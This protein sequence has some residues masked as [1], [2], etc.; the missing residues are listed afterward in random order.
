MADNYVR[1]SQNTPLQ[2]PTVSGYILKRSVMAAIS[3]GISIDKDQLVK[4]SGFKCWDDV[5][6]DSRINADAMYELVTGISNEAKN[7]AFGLNKALAN[8]F[9]KH[10]DFVEIM[11]LA[12]DIRTAIQL[13]IRYY[14]LVTSTAKLQLIQEKSGSKITLSPYRPTKFSHHQSDS[15]L[16]TLYTLLA[17]FGGNSLLSVSVTQPCPKGYEAIY[18]EAFGCQVRFEQTEGAIAFDSNWLDTP[19]Q[20]QNQKLQILTDKERFIKSLNPAMPLAIQIEKLVTSTLLIEEP[21]RTSYAKLLHLSERTLQRRLADDG[22][23]FSA[24]VDKV[25]KTLS[26]EYLLGLG[27]H[28]EKTA[29]LLGYQEIRSFYRAFYRWF[30]CTPKQYLESKYPDRFL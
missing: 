21:Q 30:N 15:Q 27:Y 14:E 23:S 8:E 22:T 19:L 12:P 2:E 13:L 24:I 3:A 7:P 4:A 28:V 26:E 20:P 1:S 16:I 17:N 5:D 18:E 25:R 29:F 9:L 6:D 11:T 10:P